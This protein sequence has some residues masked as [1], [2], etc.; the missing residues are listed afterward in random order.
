VA[1]VGKIVAV[2]TAHTKPF[3]KGMRRAAKSAKKFGTSIASITTRI[4]KWAAAMVVA[5]A[6]GVALLIRRQLK[7]ID[8]I[9]KMS[10]NLG[11]SVK[12]LQGL[13]LAAGIAG[14]ETDKFDKALKRMIKSVADAQNGLQLQVRAFEALGISV[15]SLE[16][17]R[18]DEIFRIIADAVQ[19][20]GESTQRTA[21]IMDLFG[22]RVGADLVLL[23][24]GGS[25]GIDE[26]T[27]FIKKMGLEMSQFDVSKVEA[28]ND[29]WLKLK[30]VLEG[31]AN[32]LTIEVAPFL[33]VAIDKLIEMGSEGKKMGGLVSGAMEL[34]A[35]GAA[36]LAA[37]F[38]GVK[39][40]IV[41]VIATTSVWQLQLAKIEEVLA[42]SNLRAAKGQTGKRNPFL[43]GSPFF[44]ASD[45]V[46]AFERLNAAVREVA[47]LQDL[48]N[49]KVQTFADRLEGLKSGD[50]FKGV[51][52]AFRKMREE[53]DKAREA[54][55][56]AV[57]KGA[58]GAGGIGSAIGI[59][60]S[61]L[62]SLAAS[63]FA[64]TRTPMERFLKQI[65]DLKTLL[66]TFGEDGT[67]LIDLDTFRRA[68]GLAAQE[69][70]DAA[71]EVAG[72]IGKFRQ[73]RSLSSVAVGGASKT[74][75][76]QAKRDGVRDKILDG[77]RTAILEMRDRA[78]RLQFD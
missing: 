72:R 35:L 27:G 24:S 5:A 42:A 44:G 46:A 4:V 58:G 26:M 2:L 45:P 17:K 78:V 76:A 14:V 70:K 71:G 37:M 56:N 66:S 48:A 39:T 10:R 52:E 62:K 12:A 16:G 57:G 67:P 11:V 32:R 38:D 29:A 68:V 43:K 8:T 64:K 3:E 75:N 15:D 19:K 59:E 28:A 77:V 18:P 22:T 47:R 49:G 41:G 33:T 51:I 61:R 36:G 21:A 73:I 50:A 34:A 60:L 23:L 7:A 13:R 69:L 31:I 63:V 40:A 54:A 1:T 74:D 20:T 30:T 55:D 25:K 65:Q 53:I 6:A 9:A